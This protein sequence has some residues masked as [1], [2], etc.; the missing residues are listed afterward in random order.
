[1]KRE[2]ILLA[3]INEAGDRGLTP[4]K[5]QKSLFLIG[6]A[7]PELAKNYYNFIPYN[8]GPFDKEVYSDADLL[9]DS[10]L[11]SSSESNGLTI[12]EISEDGISET[13]RVLEDAPTEFTNY[14]QQMVSWIQ[15][16]SFQELISSVY[17]KY[18]EYKVNSIFQE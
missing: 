13:E 1:M 8:Y 2:H 9:T 5:L 17:A 6:K 10:G 3:V 11:V 14:I 4:V 15:P 16:L 18:P 7:F 12:Y